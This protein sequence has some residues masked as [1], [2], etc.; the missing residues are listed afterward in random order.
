MINDPDQNSTYG[1]RLVRVEEGVTYLVKGFDE[2]KEYL[3][4]KYSVQ[5]ATNEALTKRITEVEKKHSFVWGVTAACTFLAMIVS[6]V[7]SS[8][9]GSTHVPK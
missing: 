5:D 2:L 7:F 4:D 9:F 8:L 3:E 6:T 1:E